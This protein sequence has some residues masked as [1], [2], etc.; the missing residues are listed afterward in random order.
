MRQFPLTYRLTGQFVTSAPI[1]N[2]ALQLTQRHF[3]V[4]TLI[5]SA[6]NALTQLAGE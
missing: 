2:A 6:V 4:R 5:A 3:A 1:L